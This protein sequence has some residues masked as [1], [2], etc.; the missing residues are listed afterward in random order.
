MS[1]ATAIQDA[2]NKISAAY[3]AAS[4]KGAV[5]PTNQNLSNLA[6]TIT[7]IVGTGGIPDTY[8]RCQNMDGRYRTNNEVTKFSV[9]G[10]T[11]I[12]SSALQYAFLNNSQLE[13]VDLSTVENL[14]VGATYGPTPSISQPGSR[15]AITRAFENT[16]IKGIVNLGALRRMANQSYSFLNCKGI[17]GV[18]LGAIEYLYDCVGLF[19]GCENLTT[20]VWSTIKDIGNSGC[21]SMFRRT[22]LTN[23]DFLS[24]VETFGAEVFSQQAAYQMFCECSKLVSANLSGLKAIGPEATSITGMGNAEEMFAECGELTEVDLSNLEAVRGYH[25]CRSMFYNCK[26]LTSLYFPSLKSAGF[27]SYKNQFENMCKGIPS[28]TLHFPSNLRSIIEEM[29]GYSASAPF[30]ADSGSVLFDLDPTE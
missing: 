19:W 5:L 14:A 25:A 18:N 3:S 2:Q 27:G 12:A 1:I 17:T 21:Q 26:K 9:G 8:L 10:A 6:S 15:D 13:E 30:G 28:I 22:G 29:T 23:T 24:N 11:T 4:A 16:G 7:G 20:V